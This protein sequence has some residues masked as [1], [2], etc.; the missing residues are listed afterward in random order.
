LC[1]IV[2]FSL[3]L[4]ALAV[5][6][7]SD[8]NISAS[9]VD[10]TRLL[11]NG[12]SFHRKLSQPHRIVNFNAN[13]MSADAPLL[14]SVLQVLRLRWNRIGGAQ[15]VAFARAVHDHQNLVE[16]D[17]AFNSFGTKSIEG[18]FESEPAVVL[19]ESLSS[20]RHLTRVDLS[21]NKLS[22]EFC[23]EILMLKPVINLH[24]LVLNGNQMT[25]VAAAE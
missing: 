17:L 12:K 9:L 14:A 15:A 16:I 1:V 10:I 19:L 20:N 4:F 7:L 8:N 3:F 13:S 11:E 6:D 2:F 22:A 24:H 23:L 25:E 21:N 5:L 18:V